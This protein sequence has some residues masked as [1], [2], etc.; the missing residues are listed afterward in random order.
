MR[1]P[2]WILN[3]AL[4]FLFL[5]AAGFIFFSYQPAPE[6]EEIE[7]EP[8]AISAKKTT[9]INIKNIY[10]NDPFDTYRR[11]MPSEAVLEKTSQLPLP[12]TPE[13]FIIPEKPVAQF[14]EPL[15]VTLKG[16]MAFALDESK[17]RTIIADNKTGIEKM[18]KVGDKI[19]DA[20]LL[21]IFSTKVLFIRSNGQQEVLYLREKDAMND[22]VYAGI[23]GW[24]DVIEQETENRF[25]IYP[26][27]FAERVNNL[28]QFL[29]ALD[30]TTVYKKGESV[31]CR[32]GHLEDNSLGVALGLHKGDIIVSINEIPATTTDLRIKIYKT[33]T[34]TPRLTN[35][36]V[37]IIRNQREMMVYYTLQESKIKRPTPEDVK[38]HSRREQ[39]QR[40]ALAKKHTLAPTMNDLRLKE[41]QYMKEQGKRP[42]TPLSKQIE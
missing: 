41:R 28:A 38:E 32:I 37:K 17:N 22:P 26:D 1:H 21:R 33:I 15:G 40:E 34:A 2:F 25:I 5:L 16:I 31:G 23:L 13:P 36:E 11:E 12:P 6:R 39:E 19:E 14:L 4:L 20:Q 35:V 42:L 18:Y 27:S 24:Q 30:I 10:E 3:S 7:P 9:K 29:D 8:Y